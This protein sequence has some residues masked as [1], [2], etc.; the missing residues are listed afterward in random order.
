MQSSEHPTKDDEW[1][2]PPSTSPHKKRFG[3]ETRYKPSIFRKSAN[4]WTGWYMAGWYLK[5]RDRDQA[6]EK[7]TTRANT[8]VILS[9]GRTMLWEEQY[10]KINR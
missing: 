3:I 6:F 8:P 5:E 4:E 7:Y 2:K 9:N 10:R 1:K